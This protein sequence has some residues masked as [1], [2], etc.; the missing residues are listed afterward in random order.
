MKVASEWH[1]CSS[2]KPSLEGICWVQ[3]LLQ[4]VDETPLPDSHLPE[5]EHSEKM[6]E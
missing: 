6:T 3:C 4:Y 1:L 5:Q 2:A